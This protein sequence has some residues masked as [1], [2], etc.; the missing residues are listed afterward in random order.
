MLWSLWL[1]DRA[2]AVP[3]ADGSL[4]KKNYAWNKAANYLFIE[5]PVGMGFS[6][7]TTPSDYIN[8]GDLA[9]AAYKYNL[10]R[11]LL[12]AFVQRFPQFAANF[13]YLTAES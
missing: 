5:Q 12:L 10:A 11:N 7:S 1:H 6:Y 13:L 9:A 3:Q 4:K 2:R 8:A